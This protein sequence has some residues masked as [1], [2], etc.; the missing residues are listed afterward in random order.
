MFV[1]A[2]C[3]TWYT[4]TTGPTRGGPCKRAGTAAETGPQEGKW[5]G[6]GDWDQMVGAIFLEADRTEAEGS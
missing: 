5:A 1:A 3:I 2:V 6:G 4:N